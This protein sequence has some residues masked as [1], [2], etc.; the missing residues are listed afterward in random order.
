MDTLLW[1]NIKCV[2]K[3]EKSRQNLKKQ[4]LKPL[5]VTE[6]E[7]REG[8]NLKKEIGKEKQK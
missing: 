2:R 1:K 3:N 6:A 8:R 5:S 7:K 4:K